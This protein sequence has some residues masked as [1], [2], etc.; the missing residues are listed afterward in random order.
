MKIT[1]LCVGK[2][3]ESYL[4]SACEE[5]VKRL[6]KY[7]KI[8]IIEVEEEKSSEA[9]EAIIQ[10]VLQ[11]EGKRLLER[12]NK[13]DY[14][15]LLDL[16]GQALN[17]EEFA[18]LLEGAMIRGESSFIFIIGGSNG[19]SNEVKTR[20]DYKLQFSQLTFPHQLF[21]VMV[22]EAVYRCFKINHNEK[23]HK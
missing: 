22:L 3:K 7:S 21:R 2:L 6:G 16:Q 18:H 12:M 17:S 11:K 13:E 14:V 1:L 8:E 9:N 19:V 20:A 23:Y 15:I 4:I 5:Y 10:Q